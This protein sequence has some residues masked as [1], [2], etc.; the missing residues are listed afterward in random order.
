[1]DKPVTAPPTEPG[2]QVAGAGRPL[3]AP[4]AAELAACHSRLAAYGVAPVSTSKR[5]YRPLVTLQVNY[6]R[7]HPNG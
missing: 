4:S 6:E 7:G 2:R 5:D 1:L 3:H